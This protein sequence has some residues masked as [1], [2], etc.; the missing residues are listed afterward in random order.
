MP[1]PNDPQLPK[2]RHLRLLPPPP[3]VSTRALP[4]VV[5]LLRPDQPVT[6][7][8]E[9][10]LAD[11]ARQARHGDAMARDLLWRSFEARLEPALYRCGRMTWQRGWARRNGRPWELDDLRQEAWLVFSDLVMEWSGEGAFAP[12]VTHCFPLRLRRAI[13]VLGPLR[14]AVSLPVVPDDE[15]DPEGG[16]MRVEEDD[17]LLAAV[18]A[19]LS[20]RDALVL[21]MRITEEI[22]LSEI[23]RHLGVSRRT[24]VRQWVR[25][26]RVARAVAATRL[27]R[28]ADAAAGLAGSPR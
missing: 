9:T 18:Q 3:P 21:Q 4:V 28:D 14:R 26:R 2:P 12:Y 15:P 22:S 7:G 16:D 23:A 6:P 17:E 10:L 11:I 19:A 27:Q 8:E 1:R 20:P 13:R 24:M 5:P 25:I